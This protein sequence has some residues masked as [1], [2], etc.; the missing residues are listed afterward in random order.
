MERDEKC[1]ELYSSW[2]RE[3]AKWCSDSILHRRI[4]PFTQA[5]QTLHTR[6][7]RRID[8]ST[9]HTPFTEKVV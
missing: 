5:S 4:C 9:L 1:R 7:T 2:Y 6:I 8:K 3:L